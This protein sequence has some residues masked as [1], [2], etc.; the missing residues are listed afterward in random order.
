M[1]TEKSFKCVRSGVVCEHTHRQRSVSM[2]GLQ[3]GAWCL[4]HATPQFHHICFTTKTPGVC[5]PPKK[6]GTPGIAA[7]SARRG[8]VSGRAKRVVGGG[9]EVT[10][11]R[12]PVTRANHACFFT[13]T[14]TKY[15]RW[16]PN[17]QLHKSQP[18]LFYHD[19]N[20]TESSSKNSL[21]SY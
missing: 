19:P 18:H 14:S 2:G 8:G 13:T 4:A 3:E 5:L 12:V 17:L 9:S 10:D 15:E 21:E 20:R 11:G 16:L 6:H 7:R 1:N